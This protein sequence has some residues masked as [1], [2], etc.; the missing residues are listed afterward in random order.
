MGIGCGHTF[1][2]YMKNAF[3]INF[4]GRI[5]DDPEL[6]RIISATANPENVIIA[7]AEPDS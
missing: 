4:L 6:C 7:R 5:K 2:I 1:I 3:P